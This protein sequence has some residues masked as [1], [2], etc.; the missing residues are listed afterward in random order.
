M[1][2]SEQRQSEM[3]FGQRGTFK[4][5]TCFWKRSTRKRMK[6]TETQ[7]A[8]NNGRSA[9]FIAPRMLYIKPEI[10]RP[11]MIPSAPENL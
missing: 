6:P 7:T 2:R 9:L 1:C 5:E 11:L 4:R 3:R 8:K 10:Q